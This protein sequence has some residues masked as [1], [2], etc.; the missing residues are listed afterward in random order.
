ME[1]SVEELLEA[2]R[3]ELVELLRRSSLAQGVGGGL[4]QWELI[5]SEEIG[6]GNLNFVYRGHLT[7]DGECTTIIVKY[8]PYYIRVS[9]ICNIR[10]VVF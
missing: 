6:D 8:A 4:D 2:H 10:S 7:L 9:F 5:K 3:S 1:F